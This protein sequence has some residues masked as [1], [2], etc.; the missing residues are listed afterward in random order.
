[1]N[2]HTHQT[3]VKNIEAIPFFFIIGRARSG[4]TLLRMFFDAH[5]DVCIPIESPL[6][7]HLYRKYGNRKFWTK[8]LLESFYE[9][10]TKIRDF[11]KWEVDPEILKKGI[12]EF[13]GS[14][15]FRTLCKFVYLNYHSIFHKDDIKLIG[16]KNPVYSVN[17]PEI[18]RIFPD[19]KYI[20]LTR[21]YR[22]H[23]LSM[24][25]VKLLTPVVLFLAYRWKLSA[26]QMSSM[27]KRYP[28]SFYTIRYEDLVTNP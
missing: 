7:L 16:D 17:M 11:E 28:G 4:T 25:N 15:S 14:I 13:E 12:L 9:D 21:D 2:S 20:H 18:F 24:V 1:M 6:I 23:I 3:A 8:E 10:L 26:R 19:A 5:P 27:K 22:D